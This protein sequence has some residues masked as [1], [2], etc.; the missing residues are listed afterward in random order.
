VE[1]D[2]CFLGF[3]GILD[4]PRPEVQRAIRTAGEAG[5]RVF[6]ITGD[7]GDTAKAVAGQVGLVVDDVI[8]GVDL[9]QLSDEELRERLGRS[10]LFA[11]T[12][13]EHKLRIVK[14]LQS[15][16]EV[17]AMTGDGVN[18]APALKQAD[19]GIAMGIRGTDVAKGAADV[20]LTDDNFA[21]IVAAVE[22][23]RRQYSNIQKFVRYLLSSNV[24]EVFAILGNILIGGPLLLLPVQILW[25][26]L[27]TDG[28]SAIALGLE[29]GEENAM[30]RPPH[31]V[32]A[33]II[34][35]TGGIVVLLVGLYVALATLGVYY[36]YPFLDPTI[37]AGRLQSLAFTTLVVVEMVNVFNFRSLRLPLDQIGLLSNPWLLYAWGGTFLLQLLA[38]YTPILQEALNTEA[39][40]FDDWL[41]IFALSLPLLIVG[42]V[43]KI[44][45]GGRGE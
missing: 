45:R 12:A 38:V 33:G 35:R 8:T 18:D 11:R 29:P 40:L 27:V 34:D 25:I 32:N 6:V 26:N 24:G 16:G 31:D 23:G 2:L 41:V 37:S 4:P 22:E 21:S 19:V 9:E 7:S 10:V 5:I 1:H 13:P 28:V 42:E 39:L 43:A 14:L 3:I 17:V 36:L 30:Q 15:G 44:Y 20:V